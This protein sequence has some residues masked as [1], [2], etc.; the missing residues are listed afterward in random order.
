MLG[1]TPFLCL[2]VALLWGPAPGQEPPWTYRQLKLQGGGI[3][4]YAVV[5]PDGFDAT[6]TYPVLL[7][8]P[9]GSQD[10]TMV[11]AGLGRYWGSQARSR[12]WVVV[13]PV[14]NKDGLFFRGGAK[15]VPALLRSL[16]ILL[17]VEGNRFHLAGTSNGGLAA[18]RAALEQPF[19]FQSLT[20]LPGHVSGDGDLRRL[21]RLVGMK[22]R[23]HAGGDDAR[24]LEASRRTL[25]ALEKAGVDA[26]LTVHPGEGH[27]VDPPG[28]V[29]PVTVEGQAAVDVHQRVVS[30]VSWLSQGRTPQQLGPTYEDIR[31]RM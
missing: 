13:S 29:T 9:P 5:L 2:C 18:F 31:L 1:R 28:C 8:F 12:G 24:W 20:V 30:S 7:A 21:G 3:L 14:A 25:A 4:E 6:R 19:Q 15:H 11:A 16:R 10:R 27:V 22:V 26:K 23:L 17:R